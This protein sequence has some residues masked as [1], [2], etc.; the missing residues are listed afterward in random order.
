MHK[1]KYYHKNF[2]PDDR[3]SREY[4][5][6]H[7][8]EKR[9]EIRMGRFGVVG[10]APRKRFAEVAHLFFDEWSKE[11]DADGQ[12]KHRGLDETRRVLDVNL[13]P[14]FGKLWYDEVRPLDV[15]RWREKR[16]KKV[17][18]TSVNREQAVL[19]SI[20]GHIDDWVKTETVPAF[21][22]PHDADTGVSI[23]P[24]SSVEKAPNRK[25]RRILTHYEAK[26]LKFAFANLN[27]TDG[28]EIC[29]LALKSML[30]TKD[31][32]A[33]ELGQEIDIN[34]AKTGVGVNLPIVYLK[35]LNW[36][37]WERRWDDAREKAGLTK[38]VLKVG[39]NGR[40]YRVIDKAFASIQFR[41]LRKTGINWLKGRHDLKLISEYAG[42][43]DIKTTEQSYT[44]NQAEYLK[45]LALDLETQVE[46][47]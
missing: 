16:L 19:S 10:E 7:L 38:F 34:R 31:L 39:P 21:K 14:Y 45:P 37:N 30:S 15:L 26:K 11:K 24:C 17:V 5:L 42:H 36:E 40:K 41:D 29:K 46:G 3:L 8:L 44:I 43:A 47:I 9:H 1:G 2:G 4:G 22:L 28:W 18:G 12:L 35:K 13:I 25:R 27:D 33:L 6:K 32:R 23:N 20:F